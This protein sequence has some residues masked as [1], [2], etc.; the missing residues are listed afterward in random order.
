M[1][2]DEVYGETSLGKSEG[3]EEHSALE[4]TNP[5]SAAK[6]GATAAPAVNRSVCLH[7]LARAPPF[8]PPTMFS[9]NRNQAKATDMKRP[10]KWEHWKT[11]AMSADASETS[12]GGARPGAR[13]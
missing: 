4:P 8:H 12:A 9:P 13:T 3:L 11:S 7:T 6:A 1:S 5:Y 2:T 10:K